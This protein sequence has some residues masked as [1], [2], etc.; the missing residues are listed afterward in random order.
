MSQTKR[1]YKSY[2]EFI[3]A[4]KISKTDNDTECTN[5]QIYPGGKFHI[6]HDEYN[7]MLKLY[8]RDVVSKNVDEY[9]TEKQLENNGAIVVDFDFR[10]DYNVTNK[11]YNETHIR[12]MIMLY[13]NELKKMYQ[14][15]D[16]MPFPIY[17][18]EKPDVN[19]VQ[20]KNYTKDGIHMIIG[21][22]AD[23]TTQILLR[24]RIINSIENA[25]HDI[26]LTNS[27]DDVLDKGISEGGTNW[28]LYGS[29]KPKHDRYELTQVYEFEYDSSDGEM[30]ETKIPLKKFNWTEDFPKLSVRYTDHPRF[31]FKADFTHEHENAQGTLKS[32]K[33][34]KSSSSVARAIPKEIDTRN[35]RDREHLQALYEEFLENLSPNEYDIRETAEITMILPEKYYG[36][37]SYD[38][39]KRV[40]WALANISKKL[41]IVW[42]AFSAKSP[43]F[44]FENIEGE[45][46]DVWEKAVSD[47]GLTKG[48]I[49]H[50]AQTDN[51]EDFK[52]IQENHIDYHLRLSLRSVNIQNVSKC[53]K[54][55]G[56]GDADIAK[57]LYMLCRD[58][59]ACASIKENKWYRFSGHR[60]VED[61]SGT[62]LRRMISEQLRDI[63]RKVCDECSQKL[64][65]KEQSE[66]HLK[67]VESVA[68]KVLEIICKLGQTTH[69]DHILKEARELFFDPDMKF[70]DLL[71]S[72][73]YLMC[74]NNGVLDIKNKEFR[75]G[76]PDDYISK[77]T[78]INYVKLDRKRDAATIAEI[79]DFIDK[80]FPLKELRDFMWYHMASILLGVNLDQKL[81]L[82]IGGGENGKTA[83][84][85]L[86][87]K[88]LG[89]YC[90][91]APISLICQARQKQGTAS[92]DVVALKGMRFAVMP[93][94]SKEDK[95]NDGAM[96][97]L[98]SG[99]EAIRG[100]AVYGHTTVSF[101]PQM[102]IA[103]CS[104]N[105][106]K[107]ESRDHGTWRR[108]AVIDFMSLF[109]DNPEYGDAD[110]PY[111]FKKDPVVIEKFPKWREVFMAMLVDI[112][113]ETQGKVPKCDIVNVSSEKYRQRED[114]IAEFIDEKIV[115]DPMG[116]ISK[117]EVN[118]EFTNWFQGT[119]G[120]GAPSN[121]EV[122][123]Y[124]D[125]KLKVKFSTKAGG[126]VG[127]RIKYEGAEIDVD[128]SDDED[129]IQDIEVND[130]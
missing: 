72:D 79:N 116:K 38:K 12:D 51:P 76:R 111:Q 54:N 106:M 7:T 46:L 102:K 42:I 3:H 85:D 36:N 2:N 11:Q 1:V 128:E 92:P 75:K 60:W 107:I 9:M 74:F 129:D 83:L 109:T 104:N 127:W 10:Y 65:D 43:S 87:G 41:W 26:P 40:G 82:Y 5:T 114:H 14:F 93:E 120:R 32:P 58:T 24:Q 64:C 30:M 25:W 50:W 90:D 44:L 88:C 86:L 122:H 66:E 124:L 23:R 70:L 71:D 29:K 22:Q 31:Y 69:K 89:D 98:T 62:S 112:V 125:K 45:L 96:K 59:F 100:R 47:N 27:W 17:I 21:I 63:Y 115:K 18:F 37:G 80:I 84:T 91:T 8:Y 99:V 57:I 28:Q 81:Y 118:N 6:S 123:E 53:E 117:T 126:W 94:P 108:I 15:L 39:W 97:E 68:N 105:F 13:L 49:I 33:K 73:P 103:V 95:V 35:I 56:A 48:S 110:K 19:R 101:V 78:N 113:L 61:D 34:K 55:I 77:C 20:E 119:Y 52:R 4:H 130:L 121:K 67:K 16:D